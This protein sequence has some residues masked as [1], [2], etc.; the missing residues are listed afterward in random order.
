M[1]EL[2]INSTEKLRLLFYAE[3]VLYEQ[4]HWG[5]GDVI[6]PEEQFLYEQIKGDKEII[7]ITLTQLKILINWF[8]TVTG[9]GSFL[10]EEDITILGKIAHILE[11][12][13]REINKE[14]HLDHQDAHSQVS[15]I[16]TLVDMISQPVKPPQSLNKEQ[17]K[18]PKDVPGQP[19]IIIDR[20][21]QALKKD[22]PARA[23]EEIKKTEPGQQDE[24]IKQTIDLQKGIKKAEKFVK[25]TEKKHKRKK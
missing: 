3:H 25:E 10:M 15:F 24:K 19:V 2:S 12:Y 14:Y 8:L 1:F 9:H 5:D 18:D 13:Y 16:R 23:R 21:K 11:N 17:V 7:Y 6:I 20:T 22:D 4:S